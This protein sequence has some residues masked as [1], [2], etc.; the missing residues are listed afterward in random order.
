MGIN[1]INININWI[2]TR[3]PTRPNYDPSITYPNHSTLK[4][5]KTT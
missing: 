4:Y 1:S 5:P 2:L 3:Y